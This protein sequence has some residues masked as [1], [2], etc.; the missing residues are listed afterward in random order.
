MVK[1]CSSDPSINVHSPRAPQSRTSGDCAATRQRA[2]YAPL[3]PGPFIPAARRE[4]DT[5]CAG[6][7]REKWRPH[8]P[9]RSVALKV[10]NFFSD[11]GLLPPVRHQP[12]H[13]G[14]QLQLACI[15]VPADHG[16]IGHGRDVVL[17][18]RRLRHARAV[19]PPERRAILLPAHL[20]SEKSSA[21][22]AVLSGSALRGRLTSTRLFEKTSRQLSV[23]PRAGSGSPS[24]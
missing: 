9:S 6:R 1:L 11:S 18:L 7:R 8:A 2:S 17:R 23:L 5:A 14:E 21:H 24:E 16:H 10:E 12:P 19:S 20:V 4:Q 15:Q 3:E 22:L 13:T